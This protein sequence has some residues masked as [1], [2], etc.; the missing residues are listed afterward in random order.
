M[1]LFERKGN[2]L[3]IVGNPCLDNCKAA[4]C[5]DIFFIGLSKPDIVKLTPKETN[6]VPV[7]RVEPS[8]IYDEVYDRDRGVYLSEVSDGSFDAVLAGP[9][10][11][12]Q[13]DNR[14]GIYENRP[15]PCADFTAGDLACIGI[16]SARVYRS[17]S[18]AKRA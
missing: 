5:R 11:N 4:C 17:F 6:V 12:L 7:D 8:S 10:P 15:A 13:A 9:C 1:S 18:R 14:C 16:R 3:P 2:Q